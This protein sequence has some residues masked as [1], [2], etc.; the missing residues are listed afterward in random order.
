MRQLKTAFGKLGDIFSTSPAA[1]EEEA[2]ALLER[3]DHTSAQ[4][5][6]PS[7]PP[8]PYYPIILPP[9]EPLDYDNALVELKA[10]ILSGLMKL[11]SKNISLSKEEKLQLLNQFQKESCWVPGKKTT[12]A[13]DKIKTKV[14]I[15]YENVFKKLFEMLVAELYSLETKKNEK[16]KQMKS[17]AILLYLEICGQSREFIDTSLSIIDSLN[18]SASREKKDDLLKICQTFLNQHLERLLHLNNEG[19]AVIRPAT[20]LRVPLLSRR[21]LTLSYYFYRES[22]ESARLPRAQDQENFFNIGQFEF[23]KKLKNAITDWRTLV[24]AVLQ[25]F[26]PA[27]LITCI[28]GFSYLMYWRERFY[29]MQNINT[30]LTNNITNIFIYLCAQHFAQ[31]PFEGCFSTKTIAAYCQGTQPRYCGSHAVTFGRL[32]QMRCTRDNNTEIFSELFGTCAR[33]TSFY[34]FMMFITIAAAVFIMP[35]LIMICPPHFSVVSVKVKKRGE[36]DSLSRETVEIM[37]NIG[38]LGI[39]LEDSMKT[40]RVQQVSHQS[41][42]HAQTA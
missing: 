10:K 11:V 8:A 3:H 1:H 13:T 21:I 9:T 24:W 39:R 27:A 7:V 33:E 37:A 15:A 16:N 34:H 12:E 18:D 6:T 14:M 41:R 4:Q 42:S 29:E 38:L 5:E 32:G 35:M 30:D 22:T 25:F 40:E 36:E 2:Q 20:L 23:Y 31:D 19:D 26:S 17:S 28:L